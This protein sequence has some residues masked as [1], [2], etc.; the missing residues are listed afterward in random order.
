[1]TNRTKFKK[2]VLKSVIANDGPHMVMT[3]TCAGPAKVQHTCRWCGSHN[4]E[5]DPETKNV[6]WDY[7][8]A[9]ITFHCKKCNR[10]WNE[11]A[12]DNGM[13]LEH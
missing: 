9:Y 8:Y 7:E 11:S 6:R 2:M 10:Y 4:C 5:L 13:D 12:R 3:G 1:M